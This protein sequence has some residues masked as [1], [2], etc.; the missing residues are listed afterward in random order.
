M[1][2]TR[3]KPAVINV[4]VDPTLINPATYQLGYAA[5]W[6]HI[7]WDELP[8]RGKAIRRNYHFLL[9]WDEAGVKE[10]PQPDPW[11]PVSEDE[12]IP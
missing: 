7:P 11:E 12:M 5:N 1:A 2:D 6:G 8:K 4:N 10:V 9:P 3:G